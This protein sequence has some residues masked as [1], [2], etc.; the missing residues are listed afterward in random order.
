MPIT[1]EVNVA[2]GTDMRVGR[3]EINWAGNCG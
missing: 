2:D 3:F 1:L